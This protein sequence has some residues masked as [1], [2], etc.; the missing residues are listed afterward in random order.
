MME[1]ENEIEGVS[2]YFLLHGHMGRY[3]SLFIDKTSLL[4]RYSI[5]PNQI[6]AIVCFQL[7]DV[8]KKSLNLTKRNSLILIQQKRTVIDTCLEHFVP[9]LAVVI[10]FSQNLD[11]FIC[12]SNV[13]LYLLV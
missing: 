7:L 9:S 12:T 13:L 5:E 3:L 8:H 11:I 2:L 1:I 4:N 6:G 10:D